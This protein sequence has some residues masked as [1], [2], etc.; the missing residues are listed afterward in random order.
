MKPAIL[1][2][3]AADGAGRAENEDGGFHCPAPGI[4]SPE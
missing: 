1:V 3:G 4:F 2:L